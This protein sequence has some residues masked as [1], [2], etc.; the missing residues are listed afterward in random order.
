MTAWW[1]ILAVGLGTYAFRAVTFAVIGGRRLPTWTQRPLAYVGPAAIGALVG[2]MLLTDHGRIEIA[3][4]AEL[5]AVA[6]AFLTVRRSGDVSRGLLVGFL[7]LWG[8]TA[9]GG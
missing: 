2:G 9:L 7:V 1:V 3:G 5:G 8:V 4:P 6:A